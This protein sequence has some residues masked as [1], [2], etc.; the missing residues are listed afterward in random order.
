MKHQHGFTLVELIVVIV[1]LGILAATA[2][3]KFIDLS[4]EAETGAAN[5]VAAA[6]AS[7][8]A[9]NF[10]AKKAGNASATALSGAN[11]CDAGTLGGLLT[12]G[13]PTGYTVGGTGDC[14]GTAESVTCTVTKGNKT[15]SATVTCAR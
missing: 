1:I 5:G 2:V 11:V 9:V 4:G 8:S 6:I 3:P 12:G 7:G 14:S 13:I 15:V 10:G